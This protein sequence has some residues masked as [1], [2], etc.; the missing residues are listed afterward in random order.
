[1]SEVKN[2]V[3][4]VQTWMGK[5]ICGY[6]MQEGWVMDDVG[7]TRSGRRITAQAIKDSHSPHERHQLITDAAIDADYLAE[8]LGAQVV[9]PVNG[10]AEAFALYQHRIKLQAETVTKA[11]DPDEPVNGGK[12]QHCNE[13]EATENWVG[14]GSF[15][16]Y[17]HGCYERWCK[18]CCLKV[19]LE[20]TKKRAASI[21]DLEAQIKELEENSDGEG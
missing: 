18:L 3:T 2:K 7:L 19:Q 11:A 9:I 6:L 10:P 5:D 21:P 16:D 8:R 12:C 20:T 14:E 13:R 4:Q 17:N 15:T 1:M